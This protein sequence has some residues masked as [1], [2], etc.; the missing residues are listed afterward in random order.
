MI[1][2]CETIN[3]ELACLQAGFFNLFSVGFG[4]FC[5]VQVSAKNSFSQT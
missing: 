3:K 5:H 4:F 1:L 2:N